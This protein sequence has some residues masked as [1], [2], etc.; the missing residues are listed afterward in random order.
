M[1]NSTITPRLVSLSD[2]AQMLG[3]VSRT[4][5]YK[6]MSTGELASVRV[7]GR[8]MIPVSSIDALVSANLT[9]TLGN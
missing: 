1:S 5:L 4:S 2:A 6:L 9:E 3:G 8:R 7:A